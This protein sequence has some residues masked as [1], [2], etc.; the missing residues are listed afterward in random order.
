MGAINI[1]HPQRESDTIAPRAVHAG[2]AGI[3]D[4]QICRLQQLEFNHPIGLMMDGQIENLAVK[5]DRLV[6]VLT[7]QNRIE[8]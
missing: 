5:G 6:P 3:G 4:A 7:V 8:T 1:R 2:A